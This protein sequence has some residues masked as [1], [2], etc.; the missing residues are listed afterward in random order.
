MT[1]KFALLGVMAFAYVA[2]G[3]G[4][5]KMSKQM[6]EWYE[7]GLEKFVKDESLKKPDNNASSREIFD[8]NG[9]VL[10]FKIAFYS[11]VPF[12]VNKD[13]IET[14]DLDSG[15]CEFMAL[16]PGRELYQQC[17]E[18][19]GQ[20]DESKLSEN[21]NFQKCALD[22]WEKLATAARKLARYKYDSEFDK[23]SINDDDLAIFASGIEYEVS[24]MGTLDSKIGK[25]DKEQVKV[26][27]QKLTKKATDSALQAYVADTQ[28]KPFSEWLY[29]YS[30]KLVSAAKKPTESCIEAKCGEAPSDEIFAAVMATALPY[31]FVG[32]FSSGKER[33]A[34]EKQMKTAAI[35]ALLNHPYGKCLIQNETQCQLKFIDEYKF[36]PIKQGK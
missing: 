10:Y 8:Y 22:G 13:K 1:L 9:A 30:G 21:E 2:C 5:T 14:I 26:V 28:H 36:E 19:N 20:V 33:A 31:A 24:Q 17:K 23:K 11:C 35:A 34:V 3:E 18:Q 7:E 25:A 12:N 16:N 15:E 32:A 6:D 29:E 27:A 4:K